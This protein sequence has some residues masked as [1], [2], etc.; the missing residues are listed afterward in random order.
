LGW[1]L[2]DR[3]GD[4]EYIATQLGS[5]AH[6]ELIKEFYDDISE[7]EADG[8]TFR[9][10]WENGG[11]IGAPHGL[12]YLLKGRSEAFVHMVVNGGISLN[13]PENCFE[14]FPKDKI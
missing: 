2:E 9:T 3:L 12:P 7:G 8:R 1:D 10:G 5:A 6:L 11:Y 14:D 13:Y 4:A